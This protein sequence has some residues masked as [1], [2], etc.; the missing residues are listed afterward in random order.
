M[1]RPLLF[2]LFLSHSICIDDVNQL[3]AKY[4]EELIETEVKKAQNY[5]VRSDNKDLLGDVE[6]S[7]QIQGGGSAGSVVA[8]RLSEIINWKILLLEAGDINDDFTDI[9]YVFDAAALSDRNWGYLTVPQKNGCFGRKNRQCPYIR[10]KILGGTGSINGLVYSRGI[11]RDFDKWAEAGNPGWSWDDVLPYFKR[12]ENFESK[13]INFTYRGFKGPLNTAY[14]KPNSRHQKAFIQANEEI[15]IPYIQDYNAEKVSGV[16]NIQHNIQNGRRVSGANN[17]V[18][19]SWNRFNFNVTL[20]AFVTKILINKETKTAYGVEF[21]KENKKFRAHAKLEVIVS[22]GSVNSPQLLML[23]GVGPKSEL[24][25]HNIEV[26]HDLPVGEY[27]KDHIGFLGFYFKSNNSDPILSNAQL[28]KEFLEGEGLY[29]SPS[30]YRCISYYNVRNKSSPNPNIEIAFAPPHPIKS[31]LPQFV[32]YND[33]I[34]EFIGNINQSTYWNLQLFLLHPKS[35]G[36]LRLKS[37]S[38]K[39][40]PL[41]D[42]RVF[43]DQDDL[44]DMYR[45]IEVAL[46]LLETS[47]GKYFNLTLDLNIPSCSHEKYK[48]K[49]FW[50]CVLRQIALPAYH[51]SSTTKMG[52]R[53]DPLAVVNSK[54]KVYGIKNLRVVDVGIVPSTVTG[55]INAQA[56][57]IG[58]KGADL[59]KLDHLKIY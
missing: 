2:I 8:S 9:P 41:I 40:F 38:P 33:E 10:G 30:H 21:V 51:L 57:L 6:N 45:G 31:T 58:E 17:Y 32:N 11:K 52:P 47:V 46:K 59:I 48:S 23:S 1:L 5:K 50:Y 35:S 24:Q 34:K 49:A 55:H 20:K 54:L 42:T 44:E 18:I 13:S 36:F 3:K 7:D 43:E 25:K 12:I 56:F 28:V 29:T 4:L 39:D 19:P 22:A 53:N 15:G 26:I 37:S 27:M 16:S 14:V